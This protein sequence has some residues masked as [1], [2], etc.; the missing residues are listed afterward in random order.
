MSKLHHSTAEAMLC[1]RSW[2]KDE[3]SRGIC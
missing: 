1:A 3:L 2:V